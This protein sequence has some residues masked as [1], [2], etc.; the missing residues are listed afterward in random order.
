VNI[1]NVQFSS[2]KTSRRYK[3]ILKYKMDNLGDI[4]ITSNLTNFNTSTGLGNGDKFG[5]ALCDG[6]NGTFNLRGRYIL[7]YDKSSP[8]TPIDNTLN[9]SVLNPANYD[10]SSVTLKDNYGQIANFGGGYTQSGNLYPSSFAQLPNHT[11]LTEK[12]ANNEDVHHAHKVNGTYFRVQDG[13]SPPEIGSS[14]NLLFGNGDNPVD[15]VNY[16]SG[17]EGGLA[18][19][20]H[21]ISAEGGGQPHE[22]RPPY[23]VLAYYQKIQI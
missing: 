20:R 22:T 7:G 3:R 13:Y 23:M 2:G 9:L 17:S 6:Q 8:T 16:I 21:T 10:E 14:Q 5:Y 15:Q 12:V 4:F 11:H 19:H 1:P 18:T